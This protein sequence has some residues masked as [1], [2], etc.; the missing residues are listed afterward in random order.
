[1]MD[2]DELLP[3]DVLCRANDEESAM[4][5]NDEPLIISVTIVND[6]AATAAS[7]NTPIKD[8]I[9]ELERRFKAEKMEEREFKKAVEEAERRMMKVKIYRLGGPSGWPNFIKFKALSKDAW[10]YVD[11]PLKLLKHHPDSLVVT[12]DALTSC[13]AEFGLDPQESQRPTGEFQVKAVV[14]IAENM[15]VESGVFKLN[16]LKKK[17]P[18]AE[19]KM[20][21]TLLAKARYAYKRGLYKEAL[22]HVQT[23]LKTKPDS[24]PALDLLGDIEKSLGNIPAALSAYER[25][26]EEFLKQL[27]DIREPPRALENKINRLRALDA[28]ELKKE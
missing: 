17:M 12:L 13:F 23:I 26:L 8:E 9:K 19:R 28:V 1:M 22:G 25:A 15:S 16:L 5:Y 10:R 6:A 21:E 11:W 24:L 20:E 4:V 3:I 7:Y 14:E 27:P 18:A 2:S